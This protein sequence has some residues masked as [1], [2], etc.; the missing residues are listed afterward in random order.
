MVIN[1]LLSYQ[2]DDFYRLMTTSVLGILMI[3]Q[4]ILLISLAFIH[5]NR[6]N[7]DAVIFTSGFSIFAFMSLSELVMFYASGQSYQLYWWKWGM[8]IFVIALIVILGRRFTRNHEQLIEYSH[9]LE[10]F[11]NDLQRSEKMEIISEL[12][13]WLPMKYG[14]H[15]RLPGGFCRFLGS[16]QIKRSGNICKWQ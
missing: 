8:V 12:A 7:V 1:I 2:L 5:A 16:V 10:K 14:I 6:G 3:V 15:C 11:N 13:Y 9:Q 4:I